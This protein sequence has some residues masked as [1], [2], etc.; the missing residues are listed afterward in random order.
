VSVTLAV[1]QDEKPLSPVRRADFSRRKESCRNDVAHAFQ[2]FGDF[3]K[4][5]IEMTSDVL[6]KRTSGLD[7][8]ENTGHRRP[9]VPGIGSA[10]LLSSDRERLARIAANDAIHKPTPPSSVEGGEVR[11]DGGTIQPAGVLTP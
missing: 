8:S 5:D 3:L 11:P 10:E 1:G 6:E 2:I 7:V 4:A 9:Q